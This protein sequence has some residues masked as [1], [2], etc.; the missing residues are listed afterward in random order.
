ALHAALSLQE[1][2]NGLF[3]LSERFEKERARPRVAELDPRT[4]FYHFDFFKRML[5]FEILRAK[6]YGY[7]LAVCLVALDP[8]PCLERVAA[9]VR[10]ELEA[11]IA[12]AIRG[13]IPDIDIPVH[14]SAGRYLIFLPHTDAAGAEKVG[15]R[16]GG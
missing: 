12:V 6:R 15:R 10:H 4:N 7:D 14:Y 8:Q 2:R 9:D 5:L 16:I 13:A 11:A 1:V 3:E